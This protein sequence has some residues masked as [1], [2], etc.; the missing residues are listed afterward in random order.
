[1][2]ARVRHTLAAPR[3]PFVLLLVSLFALSFASPARA[4]DAVRDASDAFGDGSP[5]DASPATSEPL[6]ASRSTTTDASALARDASVQSSGDVVVASVTPNQDASV[7]PPASAVAN[8]DAHPPRAGPPQARARPSAAHLAR[9][10]F[11]LCALLA[12]AMVAAHPKVRGFEKRAGFGMF[13]TTALPFLALGAVA[14]LP[15]VDV[16]TPSVV[17]DLRP[18][19]EFGL[20]WIG[21]RVG[22][23]YDVRTFDRMP[24]GTGSYVAVVTSLAFVSVGVAS[25]LALAPFVWPIS[26]KTLR[27]ALVLGACAA[28]SAPSGAR[29]LERAGA[30]T[31][32]QSRTLRQAT[33][34]DDA[35]PML[36]LALVT[37]VFRDPTRTRFTL[38]P[39]GWV[40]LQVGMGVFLGF[41]LLAARATARSANER[42]ALTFGG[43]AFCAGMAQY[44]GFSPLVVAF[45]AGVIVASLRDREDD[46]GQLLLELERPIYLTFFALVGATW[47]VTRVRAWVLVV[48]Y[49]A[50]RSV[51]KFVAPRI[52][53]IPGAPKANL[54]GL[55]MQP[56]SVVAVAVVVSAQHLYADFDP[57]FE[58]VVLFGALFSELFTQAAVTA[59]KRN[60][61][62]PPEVTIED[63]DPSDGSDDQD[64]VLL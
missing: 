7:S 44:L 11:G 30:F 29:A 48:A 6:D 25:I 63:G 49:V 60:A 36:V 34:L 58:T 4:Q 50:A 55:S 8:R 27:D 56:S 33:R 13:A 47:T 21:F 39:L 57:I 3:A 17:D 10:A 2:R 51:A 31:V 32:E 43:V 38:P 40:F 19:L 12:L 14:R 23:E 9:V 46:F 53:S 1:M 61:P 37:A 42:S 45:C 64:E 28:V 54:V 22:A 26:T 18:V 5:T 16:L 52:R 24:K 35:V 62:E 15:S 59:W 20:G 41:V